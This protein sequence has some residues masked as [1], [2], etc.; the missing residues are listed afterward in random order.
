Q[1]SAAG[2]EI[3]VR[4]NNKSIADGDTTPS[5]LD[6]T[7]FGGATVSTGSV[8]RTFTIENTGTLPLNLTGSPL[9]QLGNTTNFSVVAL[10]SASV[11]PGSS[12]TFQVQFAPTT[13]GLLTTTL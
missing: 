7:D 2:T 4:G 11:D 12:T 10:P 6:G 9:V 3:D 5:T 13:D 8:T 1:G